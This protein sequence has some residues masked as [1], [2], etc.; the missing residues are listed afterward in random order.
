MITLIEFENKIEYET[1]KIYTFDFLK[2]RGFPR[3]KFETF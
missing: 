2:P 1:L 3:A